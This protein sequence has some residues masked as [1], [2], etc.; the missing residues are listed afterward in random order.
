MEPKVKS[1]TDKRSS[2]LIKVK[3]MKKSHQNLSSWDTNQAQISDQQPE[4]I[5]EPQVLESQQ[6]SIS[7]PDGIGLEALNVDI[8]E[9]LVLQNWFDRQSG[10]EDDAD[11]TE[12]KVLVAGNW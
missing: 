7:K 12:R 3:K 9:F 8:E 11:G 2:P 6:W 10:V 4:I 5:S 1:N